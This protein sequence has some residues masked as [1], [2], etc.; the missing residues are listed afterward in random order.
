MNLVFSVSQKSLKDSS[1]IITIITVYLYDI[2]LP[3]LFMTTLLFFIPLALDRLLGPLP[4]WK[5]D[6]ALFRQLA[7]TS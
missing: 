3:F 1:F 5:L 6:N 4:L 2:K 7:S